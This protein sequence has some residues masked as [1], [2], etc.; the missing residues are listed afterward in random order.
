MQRAKISIIGAGNVGATCAHWAAAK[1]LGDI[2][3]VDI[4]DKEGVAKGKAID[5]F[6]ASPVERFDSEII[7][8]SDYADVDGSDVVIVTAGI[9]RK[10]GM[11]RDDLI[12]TNV[13]IVKSV[14][15]Q[16]AA[17]APDAVM[18]VVSNPLD[19]MVYTAWKASGFPTRRIVGQAGCLDVA[20]FRAFLA[21]EL[22]ISVEDIQAL[23]LGGHGDDMVPLPRYTSVHGVPILQLLP[24]ETVTACVDRAKMGGGEIVKLMGTSAYYAPASGSVQ[25]AEA[26]IKD[27]KR[28]LPCAAYCDGEYG[29]NGLFVGVPAVLGSGGVEKIIEVELDETEQALLAESASHVAELVEIVQTT[30]PELA[31]C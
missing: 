20:R 5:L 26:I 31:A 23:L 17:H 2:V 1:E 3:L 18:I 14:S 29:I 6:C 7:G 4:P 27:K 15:E 8:T 25:M 12:A 11:S 21:M 19:A 22:G 30:F 13:K 16:V 24:E 10:P 28:I 9:P